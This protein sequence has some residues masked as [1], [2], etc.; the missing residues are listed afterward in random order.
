M[1]ETIELKLRVNAEDTTVQGDVIRLHQL[2][3]NV[4]TNA[5]QAMPEGGLLKIALDVIDLSERMVQRHHTIEPGQL[6]RRRRARPGLGG[7][8]FE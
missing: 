8:S 5:V 7:L 2:M 3:M 6:P 1:P 4:C